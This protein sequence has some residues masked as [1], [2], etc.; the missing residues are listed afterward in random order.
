MSEAQAKKAKEFIT[1]RQISRMALVGSTEQNRPVIEQ[2]YQRLLDIM[3]R[4]LMAQPFLVGDRP[5]RGDFGIFGQLRQLVAWDPESARVAINRA[6]RVVNWVERTD[7]LSWWPVDG[8]TGAGTTATRSRQ[9]PSSCWARSDA[10]MRRSCWRT[11]RPSILEPR[12]LIAS[13]MGSITA[14]AR[15]RI[16]RSASCGCANSTTPSTA[17]TAPLSTKSLRAPVA[18]RY[19]T[20]MYL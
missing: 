13:S 7:D 17:P 3:Q 4:H 1:N 5:G 19:S 12:P 6:P 18:K 8:D 11:K 15:S 20:A 2:S 16:K 10:P 14:K 9:P